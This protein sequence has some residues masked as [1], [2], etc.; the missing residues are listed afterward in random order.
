MQ[1][2]R[3]RINSLST[4]IPIGTHKRITDED[5][6]HASMNM[7]GDGDGS[8]GDDNDDND[9]HAAA[10]DAREMMTR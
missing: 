9:N 1:C 3:M 8:D 5:E 7:L 10:K 2:E 6:Y 4:S